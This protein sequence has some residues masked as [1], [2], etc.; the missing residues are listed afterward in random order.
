MISRRAG[1]T[2]DGAVNS[3][4]GAH[5]TFGSGVEQDDRHHITYLYHRLALTCSAA[6]T[7]DD[8]ERTASSIATRMLERRM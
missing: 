5:H 2:S 8:R 6:S 4:A 1:E 7:V 3:T